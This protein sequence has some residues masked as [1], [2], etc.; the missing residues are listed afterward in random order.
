MTDFDKDTYQTPKYLF[1]WLENRFAW[2]HI[3]GCSNGK[4]ALRPN[5]IGPAAEG[6]DEESL[7]GQIATD[8][9]GD[10]IFDCLLEQVADSCDLQRIFVNPPYSNP[11]PF[12]QRAAE[13]KQAGHLVVMLLPADKSVEWYSI[14]QQHATEVI[15]I[16]GYHDEKGDWH[17]GRVQFI[18]PLTGEEVKGN[19]KGS[20]IAVFDPFVEGLVTRQ[21]RLDFVKKWE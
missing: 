9:L 15:D 20:M 4:N 11:L 8:F 5:W 10:D 21:V 17:T 1:R 13:L 14:I 16:I 19:N 12:V 7:S 18:H 6:L 3:D 2:F